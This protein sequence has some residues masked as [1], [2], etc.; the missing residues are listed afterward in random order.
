MATYRTVYV[1]KQIQALR[2]QEAMQMP[3]I[4]TY[5]QVTELVPSQVKRTQQNPP[6]VETNLSPDHM[7][8]ANS[9]Q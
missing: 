8:S 9:L 6:S 2:K 3:D 5:F 7:T 1:R 4:R